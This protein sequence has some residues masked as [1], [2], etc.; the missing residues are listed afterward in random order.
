M[1]SKRCATSVRSKWRQ[2]RAEISDMS[3]KTKDL[4]VDLKLIFCPSVWPRKVWY[5]QCRIVPCLFRPIVGL[6]MPHCSYHTLRGQTLGQKISFKSTTKSFVF[7]LISE[8]SARSCRHFDRTDVAH[9]FD[10]IRIPQNSTK[11]Y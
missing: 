5:E 8:I 9:L 1:R 6:P 2:L 11:P 3:Q 10:L 7:W 4:V